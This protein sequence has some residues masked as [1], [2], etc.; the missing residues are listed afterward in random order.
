VPHV[1]DPPSTAQLEWNPA[2]NYRS[3]IDLNKQAHDFNPQMISRTVSRLP[4][5]MVT[6]SLAGTFSTIF[7]FACAL[8]LPLALRL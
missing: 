5:I 8:P 2:G 3:F 1:A 7:S 6:L 4:M